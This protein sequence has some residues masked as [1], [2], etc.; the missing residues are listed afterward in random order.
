MNKNIFEQI[1][2]IKQL[3]AIAQRLADKGWAEA[4][5]GNMSVRLDGAL[6]NL[7]K[8]EERFP[9][10]EKRVDLAGEVFLVSATRSR[11]RDIPHIPSE[12]MGIVE[13]CEDGSSYKK[14]WGKAPA[15]SEFPSHLAVHAMCK[16]EKPYIKAIL[17]THPP[18]LIV[19]SHFTEMQRKGA[20][21]DVLKRMHPEIPILMP[22]GIELVDYRLPGTVELAHQTVEA[23]RKVSLVVWRM[24]GVVSIASDIERAYD[25]IELYEKGAQ[26]YLMGLWAGKRIEGLTDE[27]LKE[28][29]KVYG[30]QWEK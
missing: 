7:A 3:C 16:A 27:S 13:I 22:S 12:C 19:L 1:P 8:V 23:L 5:A 6:P 10:P 11:M 9:L 2:E 29:W 24:H 30:R 14:L 4:N 28:A 25:Q 18:H 15:T 21:N 26:L 20:L 17:H